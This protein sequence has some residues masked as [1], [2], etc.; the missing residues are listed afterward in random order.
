MGLGSWLRFIIGL[1][2][3]IEIIRQLLMGNELSGYATILAF[4]FVIFTIWFI[5]ERVGV[6]PHI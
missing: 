3:S 1:L 5:L 2:L 4:L 6:L